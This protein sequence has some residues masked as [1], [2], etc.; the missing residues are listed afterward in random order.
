LSSA[1]VVAKA[2]AGLTGVGPVV[3]ISPGYD[4]VDTSADRL[5]GNVNEG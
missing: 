2:A 5:L 4:S 3:D 1:T